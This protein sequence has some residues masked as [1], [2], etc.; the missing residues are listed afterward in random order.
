[1]AISKRNSYIKIFMVS[2]L[3]LFRIQL[4]V[5]QKDTF[6]STAQRKRKEQLAPRAESKLFSTWQIMRTLKIHYLMLVL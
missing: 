1:M 3:T 4:E 5:A 6:G 2:L